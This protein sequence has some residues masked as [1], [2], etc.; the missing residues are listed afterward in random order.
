MDVTENMVLSS[1]I[2]ETDRHLV[3]IPHAEC[4]Y[5]VIYNSGDIGKDLLEEMT[6]ESQGE[7]QVTKA[8]KWGKWTQ[9]EHVQVQ[10]LK[11]P[12]I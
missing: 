7:K 4:Y 6:S 2:S 11:L 1:K 5:R 8:I 10:I 3:T 12:G 9:G